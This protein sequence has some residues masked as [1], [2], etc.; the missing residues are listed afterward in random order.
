MQAVTSYHVRAGAENCPDPILDPHQFDQAE[1]R[2]IVFEE[3]VTSLSPG[4]AAGRR[5]EEVEGRHPLRAE[6]LGMATQGRDC[7]FPVH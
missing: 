2:I 6:L 1:I 3:Q 7:G 4:F 5:A